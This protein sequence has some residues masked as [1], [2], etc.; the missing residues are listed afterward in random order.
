MK[1]LSTGQLKRALSTNRQTKGLF[2]D[3]IA[4]DQLPTLEN[5]YGAFVI[6]TDESDSE[7]QHWFVLFY[8]ENYVLYFDSY[9]ISPHPRILQHIVASQA[10]RH[11]KLF[12]HPVRLQG[13]QPACGYYCMYFILTLTC[14]AYTLAVFSNHL[15]F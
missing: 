15:D 1:A 2:R 12:Y 7:G 6:N 11:K 13:T 14:S 4:I 9:G 8:A 5:Q 10:L 3:V